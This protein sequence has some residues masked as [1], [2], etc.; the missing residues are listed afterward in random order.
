MESEIETR[1][2]WPAT[3]GDPVVRAA[4]ATGAPAELDDGVTVAGAVQPASRTTAARLARDCF[5]S[6]RASIIGPPG[7]L[8][9][10][11]ESSGV[12]A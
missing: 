1:F 6:V 11:V 4:V 9:M 10:A 8:L 3:P 5:P 7:T 12:R 2:H